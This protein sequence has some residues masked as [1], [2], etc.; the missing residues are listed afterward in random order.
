MDLILFLRA[1]N[2]YKTDCRGYEAKITDCSANGS[3]EM[4]TNGMDCKTGHA[5]V[6]CKTI[7]GPIN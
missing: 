2:Y 6:K 5:Y 1:T 3:L 7:P 4:G